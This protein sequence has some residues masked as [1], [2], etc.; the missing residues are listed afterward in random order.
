[1]ENGALARITI[2]K[3]TPAECSF[4]AG[5]FTAHEKDGRVYAVTMHMSEDD[6]ARYAG[7]TVE[8]LPQKI[9]DAQGTTA[10]IVLRPD[11]HQYVLAVDTY[12]MTSS[13]GE[14]LHVYSDFAGPDI[15]KALGLPAVTVSESDCL[16]DQDVRDVV[17]HFPGETLDPASG[18]AGADQADVKAT[19]NLWRQFIEE[20]RKQAVQP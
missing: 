12:G 13:D 5:A 8:N 17:D 9:R 10:R 4:E 19:V 6:V 18:D 16:I 11:T 14:Q 2:L 7:T 20:R 1:M 15:R 3:G